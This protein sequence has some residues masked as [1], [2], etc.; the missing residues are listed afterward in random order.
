MNGLFMMGICILAL[1]AY[2][3]MLD[4]RI[5][6]LAENLEEEGNRRR[7]DICTLEFKLH[8][9][10]YKIDIMKLEGAEKK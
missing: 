8:D 4:G 7:D 5:D 10:E 9:V 1:F 6:T 2:V 3:I